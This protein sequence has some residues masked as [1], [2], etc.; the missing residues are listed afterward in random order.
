MNTYLKYS[1]VCLLS[2][3][4]GYVQAGNP[5]QEIHESFKRMEEMFEKNMKQISSLHNSLDIDLEEQKDAALI[6]VKN[7]ETSTLDASRGKTEEENAGDLLIKTDQGTIILQTQ[8][9]YISVRWQQKKQKDAQSFYGQQ[10]LNMT[11]SHL[12]DIQSQE[13]KI[14]YD[15]EKK[16]LTIAIPFIKDNNNTQR[17]TLPVAIAKKKS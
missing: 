13:I 9:N 2:L 6:T 14:N 12:L 5:F 7:L 1:L 10:T 15:E 8:E 17:E 11:I 16:M 3:K 4:I